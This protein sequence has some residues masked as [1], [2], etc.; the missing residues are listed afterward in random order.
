MKTVGIIE[1]LGYP[2][3]ERLDMPE[4]H[5]VSCEIAS[6]VQELDELMTGDE[7]FPPG[8]ILFIRRLYRLEARSRRAY[9][10]VLDILSDQNSLSYSLDTLASRKMN[11]QGKRS[12]RQSWLQNAQADVEIVKEIWPEIGEVLSEIMKRRGTGDEPREL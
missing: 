8:G 1:G 9:R 6:R 7:S 11:K 3:F 12:S 10:L 5:R 4:H 2:E